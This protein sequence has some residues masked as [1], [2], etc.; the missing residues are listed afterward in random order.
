[1]YPHS[2]E[3]NV[4]FLTILLYFKTIFKHLPF[5]GKK[6]YT[7]GAHCSSA[8]RNLFNNRKF[9]RPNSSDDL[10]PCFHCY[11]SGSGFA[12]NRNFCLDPDPELLFRIQQN[13]KEQI[14]KMLFLFEIWTLC[15]V[16]LQN[17]I[18]NGR[19]LIDSSS[20]SDPYSLNPD[21]DPAKNLNPDPDPGKFF[22][23]TKKFA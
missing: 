14:N 10:C 16:G 15:T 13:M 1:M 9:C 3:Q 6:G 19:Q 22:S 12:W 20:V 23:P 17:E 5:F 21:P 11:G 18:E 4:F 7:F 2:Q 8:A